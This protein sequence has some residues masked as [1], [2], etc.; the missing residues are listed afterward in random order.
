M[1]LTAAVAIAMTVAPATAAAASPP[2]LAITP[3]LAAFVMT[4]WREV[5]WL[6]GKLVILRQLVTGFGNQFAAGL[7]G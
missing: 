1:P 4:L 3:R 6:L 7:G 5:G 2:P